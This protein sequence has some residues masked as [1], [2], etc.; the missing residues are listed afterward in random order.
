MEEEEDQEEDDFSLHSTNSESLVDGLNL[1]HRESLDLDEVNKM[2]SSSPVKKQNHGKMTTTKLLVSCEDWVLQLKQ[3]EAIWTNH[4][5]G[6]TLSHPSQNGTSTMRKATMIFP[7]KRCKCKV[8][9][10][11]GCFGKRMSHQEKSQYTTSL[12]FMKDTPTAE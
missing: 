4:H 8:W 1:S 10:M 3:T 12:S 7:W 6:K 5:Q 2:L 11:L 9:R